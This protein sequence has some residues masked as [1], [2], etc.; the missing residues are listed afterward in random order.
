MS[1]PA[2][3]AVTSG[4]HVPSPDRDDRQPTAD[5][6]MFL[7]LMVAQL[8]Y[9][10]PMNPTDSSAV[11]GPV[12]AVHRAGEDAGRR[13]PDRRPA[14]R[15]DGL[16]RQR[17]GRQAGHLARRRRRP[18]TSGTVGGVTFGA[19]GPVL[20]VDGAGRP[21]RPGPAPSPAT[22]GTARRHRRP[23]PTDRPATFQK[24]TTMLRSLFAGISGLRVNQTMLDVTGNN[25]ANA[26]TTGFKSSTHRLPGHPEPDAHRRLGA[27]TPTAA[28]PTR[29]RSASASRSRR[30][31][32]T[33]PRARPR[34]PA[35]H[36]PDDPGRR[37]VR[38][39]E[40]ATSSSTPAPARSPST[41]PAPW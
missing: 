3:E 24:G 34:P 32:P 26:N 29:S 40:A 36:R 13:R 5:K 22:A 16:R 6:E 37:H 33:S 20:D 12:G 39:P 18:P 19:T 11:P 2:T 10:D 21:A 41:R 14:R 35:A 31:A 4:W 9:Q 30:P 15:A 17:P 28:A 7:Q 25:I 38:R 1:I 8:R 27:P 23:R